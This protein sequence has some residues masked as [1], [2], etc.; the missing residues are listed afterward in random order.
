MSDDYICIIPKDPRYVPASSA[1]LEAVMRELMPKAEEIEVET[2][3]GI[4]FRDCGG[5]FESVSC[6]DC[7]VE[8]AIEDWQ[9]M[10]DADFID[11]DHGFRL[12]E[13]AL[14]C[15]GQAHFL[16]DLDSLLSG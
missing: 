16:N 4:Q 13:Y 11:Q 7:K 14:P 6:P 2:D 8:L 15:C 3:P 12:K 10:M 9:E 1:E 5:N